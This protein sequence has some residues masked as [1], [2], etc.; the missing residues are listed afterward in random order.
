MLVALA[1]CAAS[2]ED[3]RYIALIGARSIQVDRVTTDALG[4]ERARVPDK[5]AAGILVAFRSTPG[6]G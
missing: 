1:A 4:I 5:I 2:P 6:Y 3:P